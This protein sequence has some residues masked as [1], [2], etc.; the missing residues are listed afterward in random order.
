MSNWPPQ[1]PE[2][3]KPDF[4]DPG[5]AKWRYQR[6]RYDQ[7][8]A[9]KQQEEILSFATWKE[10]HFN[11]AALGGRPGRPG[12]SEQVAARQVLAS[13]G[14]QN[15]ENVELGGRYPDMVRYNPD[16]STDY[17]EVGEMLQNGMPSA[18]ERTK[19]ADEIP[20]LGENDTVTFIDKMDITRRI[21]YRRG[22]DVETKTLGNSD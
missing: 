7:Y 11:P 8:L 6:Y 12:G 22:D 13:Q 18:R 10:R 17:L 21:T 19:L 20:A 16:G 5:A 3:E 15:V 14:F 9:G 1:P 2:G 4:N